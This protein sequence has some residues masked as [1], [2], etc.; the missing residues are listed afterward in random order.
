M[1]YKVCVY[2]ISKNEE[3]FAE[4][5]YNSVKE[6]DEVYV[7]DT[8][9]T[10]ETVNILKKMG[11]VV[12][13]RNI[14]PWRF[15]VARNLSLDMLPLDTDICVCT[16]LDEVMEKGWSEK[17]E[18]S[19]NKK[20]TRVSYTYNWKLEYGKPV[21]SFYLDKIHMRKGYKWIHPVHETLS[22]D[23]DERKILNEDIVVNHF[24]DESKSRS[25]YLP[26]LELSVEEDP[27]DD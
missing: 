4:R 5:W 22:Y 24:P 13:V 26:L 10:D 2:A 1:K 25:S 20:V 11:A 15:D 9:S 21:I 23:G 27:L 17:L 3:K 18:K 14:K 19:W 7:L 6:A 16:D 12:K 8:G